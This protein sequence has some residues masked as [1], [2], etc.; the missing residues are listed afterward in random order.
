MWRDNSR[1]A[2]IAK[3]FRQTRQRQQQHVQRR[4]KHPHVPY[5]PFNPLDS[6]TLS[7]APGSS[8]QNAILVQE[9]PEQ[10]TRSAYAPARHST[11]FPSSPL[12]LYSRQREVRD[13]Q[14]SNTEQGDQELLQLE[15]RAREL[16]A[17][18]RKRELQE[19]IARLEQELGDRED[20]PTRNEA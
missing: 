16:Y 14:D 17:R 18:K 20:K 7:S 10:S 8:T 5:N 15:Q 2:R 12:A 9:S 4:E 19:E 3:S 6:P 13:T 11:P 1:S